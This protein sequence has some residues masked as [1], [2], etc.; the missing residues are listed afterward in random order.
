MKMKVVMMM[1]K[2]TI[3]TMKNRKEIMILEDTYIQLQQCGETEMTMT[4]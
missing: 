3:V 4:T 2:E 1:K